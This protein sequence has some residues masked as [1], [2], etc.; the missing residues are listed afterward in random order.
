MNAVKTILGSCINGLAVLIFL[1]SG[2]VVWPQ[3]GFMLVGAIL[4]GWWGAKTSQRLPENMVR[5]FVTTVGAG[6]T[7]YFFFY[8]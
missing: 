6:M 2:L 1:I 8:A 5:L 3:A 4:G 7:L